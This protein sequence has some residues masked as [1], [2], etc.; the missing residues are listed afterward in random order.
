MAGICSYGAYAPRYRLDRMLAYKAMGW[1]NPANIGNAKGEKAVANF[2]EDCITMAVAA[3][4]NTLDGLDRT[5]LDGVSLASTTMPYKERLNAGIIATAL[6]LNDDIRT[7]DFSGGLKAGTGAMLAAI[8][9]VESGRLNKVMVAAS[10]CRI[11]KPASSQE[12]IFGDGAAAF[13]IGSENVI[14]QFKGFYSISRDFADH[15]RG[16]EGNVD[17]QWEDRWVRD[18]GYEQFIFETITG[19]LNK[20]KLEITD[21][22]KV[23]YP[24]HYPAARKNINQR[25]GILPEVEQQNFQKELGETGTA[26]PFIMLTN[27]LE[28]AVPGDKILVVSFG[29]GCDA[30]YFEVTEEIERISRIQGISKYFS[31]KAELD[32]YNKYLVWRNT[33]DADRGLRG[34]EDYITRWSLLW[35]KR[36]EILGLWGSKCKTCGTPQYPPQRVCVNPECDAVDEMEDYLFSDK[37]GQ[38]VSFTGDMLAAT[39]NPPSIYGQIEFDGGGKYIFDFTDCN[40]DELSTGMSVSMSFRRKYIDQKRGISG[41]FW[42]AVPLKEGI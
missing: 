33:L 35:R 11:G 9:G 7:T 31:N 3:G 34:E 14:A 5:E 40:L 6:G 2:D 13:V 22:E 36:K 39:L 10:D 27:T 42:K 24:C 30:L 20:Y 38:I 32:N 8:E 29:S 28:E 19:L 41:Y 4:L 18:I 37:K 25:L 23:V 15:I 1:L 16:S 12:M 17:R 21:F 26:H